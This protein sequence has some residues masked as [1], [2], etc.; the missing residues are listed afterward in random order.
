MSD[1]KIN[2]DKSDLLTICLEEEE[3][4]SFVLKAFVVKLGLSLLNT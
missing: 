2:Y 3:T 1:T 4:N